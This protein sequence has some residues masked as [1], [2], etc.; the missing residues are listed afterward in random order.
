[1]T[2]LPVC[3]YARLRRRHMAGRSLHSQSTGLDSN[4]LVI[5]AADNGGPTHMDEGM[6]ASNFP[7]RGGKS[8]L[9]QGGVRVLAAVKGPGISVDTNAPDYVPGEIYRSREKFHITDWLPTLVSYASG[10]MNASNLLQTDEP[11][12]RSSTDGMD[13]SEVLFRGGA[14]GSSRRRQVILEAHGDGG[15]NGQGNALIYDD[16]KIFQGSRNE[17]NTSNGWFLAPGQEAY[18]F[19]TYVVD[20]LVR[21][22]CDIV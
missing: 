16:L 10:G 19:S 5:V 17:Y 20:C 1:M 6:E 21:P 15:V 8:T 22:T 2:C 14:P 7:L 11:L 12:F 13:L 4:T 3:D 18:P 9:L